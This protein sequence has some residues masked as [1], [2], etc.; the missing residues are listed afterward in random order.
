M[1]RGSA[2]PRSALSKQL[3]RFDRFAPAF[4]DAVDAELVVAVGL[5]DLPAAGTADD[6][7]ELDRGT[8]SP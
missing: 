5:N 1:R 8:D 4:D 7:F 2:S 6:H 3:E